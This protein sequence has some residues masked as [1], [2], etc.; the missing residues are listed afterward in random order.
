MGSDLP[1]RPYINHKVLWPSLYH[2]SPFCANHHHHV[3][4]HKL[5][6]K[7]DEWQQAQPKGP[8][9]HYACC[10][11]VE[12]SGRRAKEPA[13]WRV[14][15]LARLRHYVGFSSSSTLFIHSICL[16]LALLLQLHPVHDIR[17]L[18]KHRR[19]PPDRV[20]TVLSRAQ[21]CP[22]S[23]HCKPLT[24]NLLIRL[25]SWHEHDADQIIESCDSCIDQACVE[26]EKLGWTKESVKAIGGCYHDRGRVPDGSSTPNRETLLVHI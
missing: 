12:A 15:R 21:V 13:A 2:P 16:K 8:L 14:R 22:E 19:L 17:P 23:S 9:Y 7:S 18:C 5:V 10:R 26:L 6:E 1:P 20:P 11:A 3:R 24:L 4:H 25:H